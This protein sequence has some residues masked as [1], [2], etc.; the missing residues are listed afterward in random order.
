MENR[1]GIGGKR[2]QLTKSAEATAVWFRDGEALPIGTRIR[3]PQLAQT[4]SILAK[5]GME[6]FYKGRIA[7]QLVDAVQKMGGIWTLEDL[8]GYSPLPAVWR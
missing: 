8:A 5:E 1:A 2:G 3:Q 6:P 4:L 7:R